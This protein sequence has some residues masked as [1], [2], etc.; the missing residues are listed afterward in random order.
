MRPNHST[1][2]LLPPRPKFPTGTI[3]PA[4]LTEREQ[5]QL[6]GFFAAI[7]EASSAR[8]ASVQWSPAAE[9][10]SKRARQK[11]IRRFPTSVPA[12]VSPRRNT[13]VVDNKF[14]GGLTAEL[15]VSRPSTADLDTSESSQHSSCLSITADLTDRYVAISSPLV[16]HMQR[17]RKTILSA[18]SLFAGCGGSDLGLRQ[19]GVESIWA[20]EKNESAC[21]LYCRITGTNVIHAGDIRSILKFPKAD[22]L[23]GCYP[24]QGY[25]QGG[26]R[27]DGDH[28]NFLYREFDR[29][30]RSIRPRAFIVEN[31]DGMRFAQ[32]DHLLN[33]Q[34]TR[35]RLAGY[36]VAWGVLNA[37]DYGL[38][39]DRRRLLIVGIQASE[40]K[41]FRFP[42][43]THGN[44]P[45]L[46]PYSTLR[47]AIW[48]LRRAP[49]NSY[50]DEPFHWYYLSRNRRRTW[51]QQAACV[52]AHWRHVGLHPDSTPLKKIGKDE[53]IF[54][55][56]CT[57]RRYSFLECAVL[58]GFPKPDD[59]DICS[60][61]L[62]FRAIG[63]AVPPPMF[64][65][66]AQALV[67]QLQN[68]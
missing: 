33:N 54:S 45:G 35:F 53:W 51:G 15:L 7:P 59:F 64:A 36:R 6:S 27:N 18:V 41:Y 62:R 65:V 16:S 31:V 14:H 30:L 28:I 17:Q 32:N 34:I 44:A 48:H 11:E 9:H 1:P 23:V 13:Y 22:I 37:K 47:D 63:N 5:E 57:A 67:T 50:N 46:K 12:G 43:P 21:E 3:R 8:R 42:G 20:N 58:Q 60:V 61:P 56:K 68:P 40:R 2:R 49:A 52:V 25:S 10:I 29:A 55:R 26:R 39:Q 24:C 66:V 38:A 19:A 4:T